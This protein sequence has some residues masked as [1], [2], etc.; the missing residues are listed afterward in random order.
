MPYQKDPRARSRKKDGPIFSNNREKSWEKDG[1]VQH[2][3]ETAQ[4]RKRELEQLKERA[5]RAEEER[6]RT[7]SFLERF[8]SGGWKDYIRI[9]YQIETQLSPAE[10]HNRISSILGEKREA[11]WF[12]MSAS[13]KVNKTYVGEVDESTFNFIKKGRKS[14]EIEPTTKGSYAQNEGG[15]LIKVVH[16]YESGLLLQFGAIIIVAVFFIFGKSVFTDS[17]FFAFVLFPVSLIVITAVGKFNL[18]KERDK[19]VGLVEGTIKKEQQNA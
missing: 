13:G 8:F 19:F 10:V 9:Q 15:T 18:E 16:E 3:D 1:P 14:N 2:E 6:V 4:K 12:K 7:P 5:R 11:K 17:A